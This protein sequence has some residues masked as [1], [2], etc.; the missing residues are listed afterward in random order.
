MFKNDLINS[1]K[2]L[3]SIDGWR[4]V[5]ILFV[6]MQHSMGK[7]GFP[8]MLRNQMVGAI[9]GVGVRFFFVIS[10]F[11]ITWLMIKEFN[12]NNR[13]SLKHFYFRRFFRIIPIFFF[14]LLICYLLKCL[15]FLNFSNSDF[16]KSFFFTGDIYQISSP[17]GHL[18]SLGV[19]E[20]Y[21][22][23][24]PLLFLLFNPNSKKL[25]SILVF[26]IILEPL[27]RFCIEY[28]NL[29]Q[30]RIFNYHSFIT[31]FDGLAIGSLGAILLSKNLFLNIN[32]KINLFYYFILSII[33]I[34]VPVIFW[35][36]KI[37]NTLQPFQDTLQ[38]FGFLVLMIMSINKP[39]LLLFQIL[40]SLLFKH[41]GKISYSIY[42]WMG[43]IELANFEFQIYS[44]HFNDFPIWIIALIVVSEISYYLIEKP[45]I[46][47][48]Y[49]ILSFFNS[50]FENQ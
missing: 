11:L 1:N 40:N 27:L 43:L 47:N 26:I 2:P 41:L 9:G 15:N 34:V 3:S 8:F 29:G 42:I 19:E 13:I 5:S 10:G 44:F 6:L 16:I 21:Y 28:Y 35:K 22:L 48:R 12:L 31:I 46:I 17:F 38:C 18:W 14:F 25:I 24:W 50:N 45:I 33:L 36:I 37:L 4:A 49:K 23:I 32:N 30:Y 20:K 7:F 39:N